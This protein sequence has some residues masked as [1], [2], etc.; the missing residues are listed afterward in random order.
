[1]DAAR[2]CAPVKAVPARNRSCRGLKEL[3]KPWVRLGELVWRLQAVPRGLLGS[4]DNRKKAA[5]LQG[6]GVPSSK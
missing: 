5:E 1:M 4:S 2:R 3:E 6:L